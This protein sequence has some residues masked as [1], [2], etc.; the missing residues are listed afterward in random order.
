MEHGFDKSFAAA[1]VRASS[2]GEREQPLGKPAASAVRV[3]QNLRTKQK[4]HDPESQDRGDEEHVETLS[5]DDLFRDR[6]LFGGAG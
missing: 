5:F 1:N 2:S 4:F 3:S 6:R